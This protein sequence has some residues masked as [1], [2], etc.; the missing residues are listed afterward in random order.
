MSDLAK[1]S[2]F[3]TAEELEARKAA[4]VQEFMARR[5]FQKRYRWTSRNPAAFVDLLLLTVG[6]PD[7][8]GHQSWIDSLMKGATTRGEVLRD[9]VDSPEMYHKYYNESFVVMSYFGYLRRTPDPLYLEWIQILEQSNG[10]DYRTLV[11]GFLNSTEYRKR[12]GP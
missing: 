6:L 11:N 4:F 1:V 2:G 8:P 7:H 3:L 9:L 10:A 5:R 12:F